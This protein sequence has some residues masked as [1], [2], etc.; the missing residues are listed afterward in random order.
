MR[1]WTVVRKNKPP[2]PNPKPR[3]SIVPNASALHNLHPATQTILPRLDPRGFRVPKPTAQNPKLSTP[4]PKSY[5][6][7]YPAVSSPD[8]VLGAGGNLPGG[9]LWKEVMGLMGGRYLLMAQA[10]HGKL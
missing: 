8:V 2:T 7:R 3:T 6:R 9:Q 4:G 1:G 10:A 5:I